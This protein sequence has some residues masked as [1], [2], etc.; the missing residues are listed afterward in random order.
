MELVPNFS[1][2]LSF[3]IYT[4]CVIGVRK[5]FHQYSSIILRSLN[6]S[7]V[8]DLVTLT[9]YRLVDVQTTIGWGKIIPHLPVDPITVYSRS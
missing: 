9:V 6:S 1:V 7:H 3:L 5:I 4:L 8:H 2:I